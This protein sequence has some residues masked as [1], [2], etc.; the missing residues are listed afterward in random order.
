M[1]KDLEDPSSVSLLISHPRP[2]EGAPNPA[3]PFVVPWNPALHLC[4]EQNQ[5]QSFPKTDVRLRGHASLAWPGFLSWDVTGLMPRK[6]T[7]PTPWGGVGSHQVGDNMAGT[8]REAKRL[9]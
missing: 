9:P 7:F 2:Q 6:V 4:T 8:A 3:W 1:R 5:S